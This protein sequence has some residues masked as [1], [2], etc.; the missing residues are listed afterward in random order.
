MF[1]LK[2]GVD[3]YQVVVIG[4]IKQLQSAAVTASVDNADNLLSVAKQSKSLD[5]TISF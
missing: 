2:H 4:R 3:E 5:V 1:F